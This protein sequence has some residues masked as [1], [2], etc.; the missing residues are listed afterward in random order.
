[1]KVHIVHIPKADVQAILESGVLYQAL[2]AF[3][4]LDEAQT[5]LQK[6]EP[7]VP[8]KHREDTSIVTVDVKDD[9]ILANLINTVLSL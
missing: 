6:I 8:N 4:S 2:K 9:K 5:W 1:M 7:H 3:S